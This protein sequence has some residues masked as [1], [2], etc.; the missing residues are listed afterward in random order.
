M[1]K[2]IV[3]IDL[4]T[5]EGSLV[6]KHD[7]DHNGSFYRM[8]LISYKDPQRL[9]PGTY[10]DATI[11]VFEKKFPEDKLVFHE[12]Y[13]QKLTEEHMETSIKTITSNPDKYLVK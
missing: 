4:D 9:G 13:M 7:F 5:L 3:D 8:E 6:R 10:V 2:K 1:I 12:V 11:A